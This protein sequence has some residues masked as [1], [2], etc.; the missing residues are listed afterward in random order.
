MT[1]TRKIIAA[2]AASVL[3][4]LP[5]FAKDA[6]PF[7]S[8]DFHAPPK[9]AAAQASS[10]NPFDQIDPHATGPASAAP[11]QANDALLSNILDRLHE[12]ESKEQA[13]DASVQALETR[14]RTSKTAWRPLNTLR[15]SLPRMK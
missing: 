3:V 11:A 14:R 7:D 5:A 4:A 1:N 6:N 12:L 8:L 13:L 15:V 10:V 9:A 2:I